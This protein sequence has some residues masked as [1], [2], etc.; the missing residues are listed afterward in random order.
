MPGKLYVVATPI[1]N[2]EDLTFRAARILGEVDVIACEDTRQTAK[3]LAHLSLHKPLVAIHEHNERERAA[4]LAARLA[5]GA[6][7]ALV[8][9]A[10]TPLISDPGYRLI[11]AATETGIPVVPLPGPCA[12]ITAL[13]ASGLPTDAFYFGGFLPAKANQRRK[14]LEALKPLPATL[15]FYEAPHRILETL[16]DIRV[17]YPERRI[18]VA[19]ELTKVHEEFLRGT[20]AEVLAELAARP[21][22]KGEFTLLIAKGGE[23]DAGADERPLQEAIAALETEG[24]ERMEAIKLVARLR[25]LSKREV[26]SALI[27]K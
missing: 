21:A 5:A 17:C 8:S 14:Y 25:G 20:G 13:S 24:V 2:L 27:K 7:I 23:A 4:E 6:S 16:E 10:G 18:T 19:R 26:Y 11:Q 15:I 1:G 3:L 22:M 9:D 12:A